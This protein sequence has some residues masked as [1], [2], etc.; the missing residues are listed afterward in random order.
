MRNDFVF[1]LILQE[2][3]NKWSNQIE[4]TMISISKNRNNFSFSDI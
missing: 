3:I 1:C 2:W 4:R